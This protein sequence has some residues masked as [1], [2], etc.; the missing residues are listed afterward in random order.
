MRD[1]Y[2]HILIAILA[3][4]VAGCAAIKPASNQVDIV[5]QQPDRI[6][7]Q[8]K[9]A[10][11]AFALMSTMGPVGAALGVAIDE[12]IAKDIRQSANAGDIDFKELLHEAV[13][14]G[15]FPDASK[16][17]VSRYGFVIKDGSKDYVAAEIA[18]TVEMLTNGSLTVEQRLLSSWT[19][20]AGDHYLV[21]LD[22]IKSQPEKIRQLFELA[23]KQK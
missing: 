22:E 4:A 8:G 14:S 13:A 15:S 16:I 3:L 23:L 11:A 10:G 2:L 19:P 21:T 17:T 18:L 6:A 12:G 20:E 9:G 1:S 5:Y 7:F